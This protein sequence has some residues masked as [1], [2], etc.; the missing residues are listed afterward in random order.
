MS[1]AGFRHEALLYEGLAGFVAGVAPFVREG[2]AAGEPVLVVAPANK[3]DC[4]RE[5]L[6]AEAGE[7]ELA[8]M[9]D[10]GANPARIIPAW[11]DFLDRQSA[12]GRPVRGVGEP[13]YRGRRPDELVEC[14]RHEA[15][16]NLAFAAAPGFWLLCPYDAGDLDPALVRA[17]D[18]THPY[19][20]ARGEHDVS[21][22]YEGLEGVAG[23]FE[24]PLP[25]PPATSSE[26]AFDADSLVA[27]R[28]LV[29]A[30]AGAGGLPPARAAD[31][32]VAVNEVAT[33]SL[34]HGGGRGRLRFWREPEQACC[35]IRDAGRLADPLA[36]RRRPGPEPG[37]GRGLWLANQLCD[38][39][40]LRATPEGTAVRLVMRLE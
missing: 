4:L 8:D 40:Q 25:E 14:Q 37:R 35:E 33:N 31:L 34:R 26:V 21:A 3:L 39:V 7:V 30:E 6:G 11:Q 19:L 13:V 1:V 9:A 18:L 38:L 36:G 15:L 17:A 27:L 32:V 29:A 24:S 23:P 10:V 28:A 22:A 5:E 2:L 20:W 12:R 16:L